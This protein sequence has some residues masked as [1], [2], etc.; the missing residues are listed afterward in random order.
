M[1][2]SAWWTIPLPSQGLSGQQGIPGKNGLQGPKVLAPGLGGDEWDRVGPG[3][4]L[5]TEAL[6]SE[7]VGRL[8]LP[9]EA[10]WKKAIS[11]HTKDKMVPPW[12]GVK[13]G[14]SSNQSWAIVHPTLLGCVTF[15]V[16]YWPG[17][18]GQQ[19]GRRECQ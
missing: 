15:L 11:A 16:Q 5:E 3:R 13:G 7:E 2:A 17:P 4:V 6:G 9:P 8:P 18:K 12:G 1:L 19:V 14:S 10:S